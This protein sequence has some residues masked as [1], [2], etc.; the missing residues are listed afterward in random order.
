MP[1]LNVQTWAVV[2]GGGGSDADQVA[3]LISN[4]AVNRTCQVIAVVGSE[5]MFTK[6][7]LAPESGQL[8]I[9]DMK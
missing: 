9:A 7:E 1:A 5:S 8:T 2:V 3:T 6:N 4:P